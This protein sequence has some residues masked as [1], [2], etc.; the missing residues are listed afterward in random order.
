MLSLSLSPAVANAQAPGTTSPPPSDGIAVT[1]TD[2][3][4]ESQPAN[5]THHDRACQRRVP[6]LIIAAGWGRPNRGVRTW[7]VHSSAHLPLA[8]AGPRNCD[9]VYP[10]PVG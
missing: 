10:F 8:P 1:V 4:P 9:V 2:G 3:V 5:T 7:Y 6:Y